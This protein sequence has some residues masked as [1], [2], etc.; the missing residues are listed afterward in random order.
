MGTEIKRNSKGKYQ[1]KS[2][3][4]GEILHTKRWVTEEEAKIALME[5]AFFNFVDKIIEIDMDFPSG[6]QINGLRESRKDFSFNNWMLNNELGGNNEIYC[7]KMTEVLNKIGVT[8]KF[9]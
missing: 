1:M 7:Q 5:R 8:V 9:E 2:S 6:Y 3:I 4:S